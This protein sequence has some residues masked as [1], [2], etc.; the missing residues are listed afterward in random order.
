MSDRV[1]ARK[2]RPQSFDEV[3]GQAHVTTA[4]C[5]AIRTDRIP[6]AI[7]ITV[8]RGVGKA[9]LARLIARSINCEKGPTIQP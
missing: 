1:I 3:S 4:L 2:W 7:L 5:N 6:H 8:S 9:T